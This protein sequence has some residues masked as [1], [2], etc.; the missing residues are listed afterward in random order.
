M[1]ITICLLTMFFGS[2]NGLE[3][4][5]FVEG[6]KTVIFQAKKDYETIAK[7]YESLSPNKKAK[8]MILYISESKK[9]ETYESTD[10]SMVMIVKARR[11]VIIHELLHAFGYSIQNDKVKEEFFCTSTQ[12]L[13]DGFTNGTKLTVTGDIKKE[14]GD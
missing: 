4:Q 8:K 13:F 3:I 1:L 6:N 14:I 12:Y 7:C 2:P 11:G 10:G 9:S 5:G